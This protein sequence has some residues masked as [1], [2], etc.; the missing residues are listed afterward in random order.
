VS[1]AWNKGMLMEQN[2][3][4]SRWKWGASHPS[5]TVSEVVEDGTAKVTSSKVGSLP[6]G[7]QLNGL[8][9][10][11]HRETQSPATGAEQMIQLSRLAVTG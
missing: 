10:H 6:S 5:G 8:P 4:T 7:S 11:L 3:E 2:T 1:V 9:T